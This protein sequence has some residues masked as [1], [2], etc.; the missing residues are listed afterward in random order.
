MK[1]N[2][3]L[4]II[5][6]LNVVEYD[7]ELKQLLLTK[8]QSLIAKKFHKIEKIVFH[9]AEKYWKIP[10]MTECFFEAYSNESISVDEFIKIFNL[11]DWLYKFSKTH[12]VNNK[13]DIIEK[14][15]SAIWDKKTHKET[16]LDDRVVW[17][18]I[19]TWSE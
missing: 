4:K 9:S 12:D 17:A 11:K 5:I 19:Y 6:Q 15:E 16:L 8:L 18:H 14:D 1:S 10:K 3:K 7:K 2:K 13:K